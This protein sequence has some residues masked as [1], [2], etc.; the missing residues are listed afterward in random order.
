MVLRGG[1]GAPVFSV[2]IPLTSLRKFREN[3][4]NIS[5]DS[6]I[7]LDITQQATHL[8]NLKAPYY[9][10]GLLHNILRFCTKIQSIPSFVLAYEDKEHHY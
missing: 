7:H 6:K 2:S 10:L 5:M 1:G 9:V 4:K 3:I 8:I